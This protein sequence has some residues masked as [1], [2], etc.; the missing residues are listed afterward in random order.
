MIYSIKINKTQNEVHSYSSCICVHQNVWLLYLGVYRF[1]D[2]K[3]DGLSYTHVWQT[4]FEL[5]IAPDAKFYFSKWQFGPLLPCSSLTKSKINYFMSLPVKTSKYRREPWSSGYG[6]RLMFQ[7]LWVWILT[8][9]RHF[10]NLFVV[11]TVMFVWTY[12]NK[13]KRGRGWSIFKKD[14]QVGLMLTRKRILFEAKCN[15]D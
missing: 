11:K 7:R 6:R 4:F 14:F 5:E 3:V 9:D 10:S 15:D 12:E 13:R 8:P 1:R 2:M